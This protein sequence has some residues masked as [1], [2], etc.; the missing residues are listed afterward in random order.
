MKKV[1]GTLVFN[2]D[3]DGKPKPI[4]NA[5]LQLWDIDLV[6]N[7]FLATGQTDNNGDFEI[8]YD[9]NKGSRWNDIPDLVLRFVDR[10]YAYDKQGQPIAQWHIVKS[11]SGGD[12]ITNEVF[13]F[14][15]LR[16]AFWEYAP[17]EGLNNIAFTPRVDIIDGKPP[18]AQRPGRVFEQLQVGSKHFAIHTKHE[19]IAKFSKNHPT[20][21]EIEADYPLN[22]TRKLSAKAR[23]DEFI[24]DLVLNGFNPCL[25]KKGNAA[26]EFYVDFKWDGLQLDGHHFAPN[27]TAYFGLKNGQLALQSIAL[28]KRIGGSESAHALLRKPSI[29]TPSDPEWE[30]VKRLFR[31]NYFLFGEVETHMAETHLNVEQYIIPMR[32][33]LLQNPIG[34]LMFPHFYGTVAVNLAANDILLSKN[35]LIQKCSALTADSVA[36]AARLKFGSL[37]WKGW[38]PRKPLCA[39]HKFALLGQLYWDVLNKYVFDFIQANQKAIAE[40]WGEIYNMSNE[41]IAHALPFIAGDQNYY[42]D[43]GEINTTD[44]LHPRINGVEVAISPVTTSA[45]ADAEGLANLQELCVYLLFNTTFKHSWFNDLQY[46]IGGEIEFAT[47][48]VT[49]DISNMQVDEHKVVPPSEALE[50]PFITYILNYTKYGYVLRNEDDDMNPELIKALLINKDKFSK[51]GYDVRNLRSC[52][53][54]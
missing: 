5:F 39:E 47:L 17:T 23:S 24:S 25:L 20:N 13:D 48:G 6:E 8:E 33:N 21:T 26:D 10:E 40:Y 51:L 34:R 4:C 14:G 32:R 42:Y 54:T 27:T 41:L 7:D 11:F 49:D 19:L 12:N 29:Y 37:N 30:R 46:S 1:K 18:Q 45:H 22:D 50:H 52:I 36:Q 31:C 9:P 3:V 53:N 43:T 44:K 15:M 35:G 16:A 38:R 2:E 28:Q